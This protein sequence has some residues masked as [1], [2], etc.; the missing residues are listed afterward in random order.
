MELDRISKH[1]VVKLDQLEEATASEL[2]E[3]IGLDANQSIH[4]RMDR[5][6]IPQG[7]ALEHPDRREQ[8]GSRKAARVYQITERGEDWADEHGHEITLSDLDEAEQEIQRLSAEVRDLSGDI[9][10]LKRW[11]QEQAGRTGGVSNRLSDLG[12][13]VDE[14]DERMEKHDRRDY[15]KI[16]DQLRDLDERTDR[17]DARLDEPLATVEQVEQSVADLDD[18]LDTLTAR[19][20]DVDGTQGDFSEWAHEMDERVQRL[21]QRASQSLLQR[22]WPF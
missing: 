12:E 13:R 2:K 17:L 8:P 16:W 10:K 21:E 7:L 14:L 1:V 22:L 6:L 18:R 15:S 19:L 9:Q 4:Y 3:A 20:D 5:K 11:R